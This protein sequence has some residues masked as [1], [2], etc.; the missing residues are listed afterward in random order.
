MNNAET[1][2]ECWWL[3]GHIDVVDIF[4]VGAVQL[5]GTG[6]IT[7]TAISTVMSSLA[8][9]HKRMREK[10]DWIQ[11]EKEKITFNIFVFFNSNTGT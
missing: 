2:V 9:L 3:G 6:H 11:N 1:G 4:C 10:M 5:P 8:T 7:D